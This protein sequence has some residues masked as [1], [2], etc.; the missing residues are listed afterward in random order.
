[1]FA[2]L[3]GAYIHEAIESE[4]EE[5]HWVLGLVLFTQFSFRSLGFRD[6]PL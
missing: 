2:T 5:E 4:H 6:Q 3:A 1:V